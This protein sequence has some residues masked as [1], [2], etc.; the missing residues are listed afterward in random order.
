[1]KKKVLLLITI[2]LLLTACNWF[3][4]PDES[5][6]TSSNTNGTSSLKEESSSNE[7][8]SSSNQAS[9][10]SNKESSS[11]AEA[12]SSIQASSSS[13]A[14]S[15]SQ[16][17]SSIDEGPKYNLE[18]NSTFMKDEDGNA[19]RLNYEIP[20]SYFSFEHSSTT[21]NKQLA[22]A[23][24]PFVV[25]APFKS[26]VRNTYYDFGFDANE[27]VY[28]IDYEKEED[29]NTLLYAIGHKKVGS[30]DLVN[31]TISGYMY[32]KPWESNF[33][34]GKTGHHQGFS[35]GLNKILPD[36]TAYLAKYSKDKTKVFINGYS[37]AAAIG[38]LLAKNLL[39]NNLTKEN[40]L[41]AYLFETPRGVDFSLGHYQYPSIFNVINSSDLI[42]YIAPRNY[43]FE[44]AGNDI[45][46]NK[47]NAQ[48]ILTAFNSKLVLPE[49]TLEAGKY[50]NDAEFINYIINYLLTPLDGDHTA[51]DLSTR[52]HYVD[53]AQADMAYF[54]ALMLSLPDA[55]MGHVSEE[56]GKL[57]A[58]AM[59]GLMAEDGMY[60]FLK[61][62]FDEDNINYDDAKLRSSTNNLMTIGQ[63]KSVLLMGLM[64]DS[65]KNNL[66]RTL[67]FHA[68]E[69]VIPLLINY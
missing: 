69:T 67:D 50:S 36:V 5:K 68:L 18:F 27:I 30:Y 60:N 17:S 3:G 54:V 58:W 52:E 7:K 13:E 15:S 32:S 25:S 9:S 21:F 37:R 24:L 57:S 56:M 62:I 40:N 31:I 64:S 51:Q 63:Q 1:M 38:N 10:V 6:E 11:S 35:T 16:A 39:D 19:I 33:T 12:S 59:I 41:Y 29:E 14:S 8:E 55:T 26:E 47:S 61:P 49:F 28:S 2:P 46:I 65:F 20:Y 22:I 34:I 53:N 42:T 44:R 23:T 45:D 4:S 66:K 43:I 48:E